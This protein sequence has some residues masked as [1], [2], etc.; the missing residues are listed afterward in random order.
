MQTETIAHTIKTMEAQGLLM[1]PEELPSCNSSLQKGS[2]LSDEQPQLTEEQA[3]FLVKNSPDRQHIVCKNENQCFFGDSP[4]LS[5]LGRDY[6]SGFPKAWL[7]PQISNVSDYCGLKQVASEEQIR[8]L[9]II[10]N[11]NYYWLKVDELLLFFF[12]FKSKKY[13]CFYSYFD[14]MVILDSLN[15]FLAERSRAYERR[16]H[17]E[18]EKQAELDR[19]NAISY[20]EYLRRKAN[21]TLNIKQM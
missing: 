10:I 9:A 13:K 3:K 17:E 2:L 12:H 16:E 6:G 8:E 18:R 21:V 5:Q 1:Q 15:I 19:R 11:H 20:E 14:P 7:V 4:T